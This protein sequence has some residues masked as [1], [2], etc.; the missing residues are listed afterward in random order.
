MAMNAVRF[1]PCLASTLRCLILPVVVLQGHLRWCVSTAVLLTVSHRLMMLSLIIYS[2]DKWRQN[3]LAI[4][5]ILQLH[6]EAP[7]PC[8]KYL[9]YHLSPHLSRLVQLD[10]S[11]R[12]SLSLSAAKS[13]EKLL[14][15][16]PSKT[17]NMLM[18]GSSASIGLWLEVPGES[19][20]IQS[21]LTRHRHTVGDSE[22]DDDVGGSGGSVKSS[23]EFRAR[24]SCV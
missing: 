24:R 8:A 19:H 11:S 13:D 10:V 1:I 18:S 20:G 5:C 14:L 6:H 23:A 17:P 2:N 9:L 4:T 22:S 15:P 3:I 16:W 21:V 7:T 12:H